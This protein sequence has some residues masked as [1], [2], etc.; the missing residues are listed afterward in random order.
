M[1]HSPKFSE[2]FVNAKADAGLA[3]LDGGYLRI[4]DGAK[5]AHA[6]DAV[7]TQRLLATLRWNAT[8]FDPAVGGVAVARAVTKDDSAALDGTATWGR[9]LKADGLSAVFDGTVGVTGQPNPGDIY[10]FAINAADIQQG[11]EVR[12]DSFSYTESEG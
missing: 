4:Y 8:A 10:E 2:D 5:P 11:A 6:D 3:L 7:T 1:A 9:A 12:M